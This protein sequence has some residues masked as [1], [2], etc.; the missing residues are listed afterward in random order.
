MEF[1]RFHVSDVKH[2][3]NAAF[4]VFCCNFVV[5]YW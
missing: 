3:I 5:I 4:D 2:T 1:Y